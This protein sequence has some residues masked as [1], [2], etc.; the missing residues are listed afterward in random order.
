MIKT[1]NTWKK[2]AFCL[3]AVAVMAV[4]AL[5]MKPATVFAASPTN[6]VFVDGS[7]Q[8]NLA[9]PY[10]CETS[11][12]SGVFVA[13]ATGTLDG[14]TCTAHFHYDSTYAQLD[15]WNYNGGQIITGG[16]TLNVTLTGNNIVTTTNVDGFSVTHNL[17]ITSSTGG[18]LDI[19]TAANALLPLVGLASQ[20][21]TTISGNAIVY[22][23][24]TS[25]ALNAP[26]QG[27]SSSAGVNI[28]DSSHLNITIIGSGGASYGLVTSAGDININTT[29]SVIVDVSAANP[30]TIYASSGN[31][32]F[33][34][35]SSITLNFH[36][37]VN[38]V[39]GGAFDWTPQFTLTT[40]S[41]G[42]EVYTHVL[43]VGGPFSIPASTV[44]T[45]IVPLDV[46]FVF[47]GTPPYTFSTT[48]LPAGLSINATTGVITGTP[49]T[50]GPAGTAIVTVTDSEGRTAN[51]TVN[52]GAITGGTTEPGGDG[53]I[54][55]PSTGYFM[56]SSQ[57]GAVV[58]TLALVASLVLL[59]CGSFLV[60]KR[61]A[62]K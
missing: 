10:Y 40:P 33:T 14:D 25:T 23:T 11:P 5:L 44:G 15:L 6:N 7:T 34:K 57:P 38:V 59:A 37:G 29:N 26:L 20:E 1:L 35:A 55:T 30:T 47:G 49:T 45:P 17:S 9:N 41:P 54:D 32:N 8:L 19:Y 21:T 31:V 22:V 58:S 60:A 2:G 13:T 39:A 42:V 43:E 52:Y 27:V 36:V 48:G 3:I 18:V 53:D 51:I 24:V 4:S 50:A 56:Q 12:G 61:F 28:I 62:R 16:G 46:G